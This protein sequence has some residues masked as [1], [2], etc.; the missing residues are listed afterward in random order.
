MKQTE[1]IY[2]V[3][4]LEQPLEG[5][6]RTEFFFTSLSAIYEKFTPEQ[7]GCA[8]PNLWNRRVE[9]ERPYENRQHTVS[10]FKEPLHRK[11][12]REASPE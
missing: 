9:E 12:H 1:Y 7:I 3:K 10:I 11:H 4:F 5:D 8:L 6:D 2:R